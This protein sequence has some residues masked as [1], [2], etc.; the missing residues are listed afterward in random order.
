MRKLIYCDLCS[1][2]LDRA[3]E[4]CPVCREEMEDAD[5]IIIRRPRKRRS[6]PSGPDGEPI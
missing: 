6:A 3:G 4:Q 2:P 5:V 1:Y